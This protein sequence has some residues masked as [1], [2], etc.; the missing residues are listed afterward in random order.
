MKK[1]LSLATGEINLMPGRSAPAADSAGGR[2][3][4]KQAFHSSDR[5]E[6]DERK[7]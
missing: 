5:A 7:T 2:G 3:I 6:P 4:K 1:R